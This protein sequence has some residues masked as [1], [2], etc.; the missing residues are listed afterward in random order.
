MRATPV[1]AIPR[2]KANKKGQTYKFVTHEESRDL[3]HEEAREYLRQRVSA[4]DHIGVYTSKRTYTK[5]G[6]ECVEYS[7]KEDQRERIITLQIMVQND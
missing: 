5:D 1:K 4:K 7:Y 6:K 3:T 2:S